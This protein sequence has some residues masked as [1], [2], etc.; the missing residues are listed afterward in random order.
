[1]SLLSEQA[2]VGSIV[3]AQELD[4]TRKQLEVT[5]IRIRSIIRRKAIL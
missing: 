2:K 1:M 5:E 4:G 3:I